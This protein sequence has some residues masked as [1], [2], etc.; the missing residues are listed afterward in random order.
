MSVSAVRGLAV[1]M[2]LGAEL[3]DDA[4]MQ[5]VRELLIFSAEEIVDY[6]GVLDWTF[7]HQT[8]ILRAMKHEERDQIVK[9]LA[10]VIA[11][12]LTSWLKNNRP[13]DYFTLDD[14]NEDFEEIIKPLGIEPASMD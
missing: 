1:E 13:K 10:S 5:L 14:P 12:A 9:S 3:Q 6:P 7:K 4:P 11:G 8:N 2:M